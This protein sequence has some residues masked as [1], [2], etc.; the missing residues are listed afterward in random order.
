M[1]SGPRV[2][3]EEYHQRSAD[4]EVCPTSAVTMKGSRRVMVLAFEC[5]VCWKEG[6]CIASRIYYDDMVL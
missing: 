5:V 3:L 4:H 2:M 6:S 1:V